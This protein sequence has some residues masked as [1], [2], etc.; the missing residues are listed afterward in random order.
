[1]GKKT[2]AKLPDAPPGWALSRKERNNYYIGDMGRRAVMN[3]M[4]IFMTT[5][6]LFQGIDPVKVAGVTAVIKLIDAFDD[7]IFGFLV[8][9]F[10]VTKWKWA[11]K[12][13]GEGKY[14]PW[15]RLT[16]FTFPLAIIL[17][18]LM[19][20]SL[21]VAGKLIWYAVTYLLYDLTCTLSEVPM[22]S[23]IMTLT[24][25]TDERSRNKHNLIHV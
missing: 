22:N 5:F 24:D 4:A 13:A 3:V 18:F 17:F 14:L 25:N 19:P 23:L 1:M 7:V 10:D 9:R 20:R 15:Y 8:D 21:P 11:K 12:L 6:L 16:Y 2:K